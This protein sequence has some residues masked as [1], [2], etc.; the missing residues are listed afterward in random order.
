MQ[1][2]MA[3]DSFHKKILSFYRE[4]ARDL[5]WR[6][7][8]DRYAIMVSEFM[9]QQTQVSRVIPK[10][11]AWIKQYPM[12]EALAQAPLSDVL[13]LWQGLGYNNRAKRL[14]DA[15]K[16][17]VEKHEG[18]VPSTP[19][20]LI[21]LPGIGPYMA[22]SILIFADNLDLAAVDTNIRRIIIHEFD[23]PDTTPDK[24]LQLLAERV[25]P[26]GKSREWHN[27]LM[28]YGAIKLTA[29]ASGIAPK[30]KQ[31]AFAGS[32]RYYRSHILKTVLSQGTINVYELKKQLSE[33]PYDI[34][35][36]ID[37]MTTEGLL[38][39]TKNLISIRADTS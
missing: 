21:T 8:T 27:A 22:R 2:T 17:I 28:D 10:Y 24:D 9:L 29:R 19:Q 13:L 6:N 36:I 26:R 18:V 30:T 35:S 37:D 20:E 12:P 23:L 5:P 4:Y 31:S 39:R 32:K 3:Y 15:C 25:L 1:K 11:K 14:Q 33:C 16:I 7:T 34:N 38:T